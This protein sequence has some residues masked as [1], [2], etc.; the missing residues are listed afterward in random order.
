MSQPRA[1]TRRKAEQLG[2][3]SAFLLVEHPRT[4]I[5]GQAAEQLGR[6]AADGCAVVLVDHDVELMMS[7]C[8]TITVLDAGKVIARGKPEDLRA[9]ETVRAAYLGPAVELGS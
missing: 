3:R 8:D 5:C 9:N 1:S 4:A 2:Q 6:L 7:V